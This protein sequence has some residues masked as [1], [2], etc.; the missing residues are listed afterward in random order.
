[1]NPRAPE[2]LLVISLSVPDRLENGCLVAI[3]PKRRTGTVRLIGRLRWAVV[4][5]LLIRTRKR[6]DNAVDLLQTI[7]P[8]TPV[9][10]SQDHPSGPLQ[11]LLPLYVFY[12]E[13]PV[14][15]K[16]PDL[17]V[18]LNGDSFAIQFRYNVDEETTV[19]VL[20]NDLNPT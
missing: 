5:V 7:L 16:V 13:F 11:N 8:P 17:A 20:G 15:V 9:G 2:H 1:V 14:F 19:W 10:N 3:E 12:F 6:I 4:F 18:A